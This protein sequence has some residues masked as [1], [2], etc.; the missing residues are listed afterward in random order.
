MNR[1]RVL[2]E[3]V[4]RRC[5]QEWPKDPSSR[6]EYRSDFCKNCGGLGGHFLHQLF[7]LAGI[8]GA[9]GPPETE[10]ILGRFPGL[11]HRKIFL[12]GMAISWQKGLF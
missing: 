1:D 2:T 11:A 8:R 12:G 3:E 7:H 4:I 5:W 9:V 6:L 10:Q